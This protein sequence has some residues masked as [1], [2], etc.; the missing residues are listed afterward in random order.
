[1]GVSVSTFEWIGLAL[2]ALCAWIFPR[3]GDPF[4]R[5]CERA[6]GRFAQR[7][8][9]A[10][11]VAATA[12]IL[13]R[14]ALLPV[15]PIPAP[16][17]HDEFSYLLAA[18]T[19]AHGRLTNPPHPMWLSFETFHVNMRP[20]YAS[21]YPPAQGMVLA[22][23][24]LL[25]HPW[26]GVL[27]S[28]GAMCAAICWMLQGGFPPQWAL[29]G[30]L[31][32]AVRFGSF[33]YWINSYWGGAV[34]AIGGALAIGALP[35]VLRWQRLR[36]VV[37]LAAGLALLANSRPLEGLIFTIPIAIW[38]AVWLVR[39]DSIKFQAKVCRTILPLLAIGCC[40]GSWMIYYNW[41]LTGH[42]FLL[43]HIL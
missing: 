15:L 42:P 7:K 37:M 2:L 28:V 21:K 13:L 9:L 40:A 23:G 35:R 17:I 43:P 14:L 1:M 8:Q 27:L 34:A 4:F 18:D 12:P 10:I 6:F 22:L 5:S 26:L 29:F 32:A 19:F 33:S 11:L 3:L 16:A 30:G 41:H 39:K 36:D 24:Q 25:W 20:T 31:L 38:L